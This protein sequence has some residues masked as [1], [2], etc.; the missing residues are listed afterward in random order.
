MSDVV[1][2]PPDDDVSDAEPSALVAATGEDVERDRAQARKDAKGH[3]LPKRYGHLEDVPQDFDLFVALRLLERTARGAPRIGRSIVP[4][5][6]AVRLG[7]S[8]FLDFPYSNISRFEKAGD[9]PPVLLTRFLGYFGPNGAL[10]LSTTREAFNWS[11]RGDRSFEAFANLFA[12]RPLQLFFRGWSDSRAITQADRPDDDR[13]AR[14]LGAFGG[15]GSD[16]LRERDSVDDRAKLPF[17]GLVGSQ[18]RSASRLK[19][20]LSGMFGAPVDVEERIGTWLTFE[21]GDRL[22][23]D[24]SAALGQDTMIGDRAYSINER[25]RIHI[26]TG[27]LE[28]Y[29]SFLPGSAMARRLRDL[30]FLMLGHRFEYDVELALPAADAPTAQLGVAGQL[31][32]TAWIDPKTRA[33]EDGYLRDARVRPEEHP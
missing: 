20:F 6:D 19:Q 9:T 8:P 4:Q 3:D 31:G 1:E 14:F 13:F 16:A 7:Q 18:V 25:F 2:D 11:R 30:V 24:G 10:P 22:A 12:N 15:I 32:W 5:E 28:E 17:M 26:R 33:P 29:K 23:M 21:P 27:S